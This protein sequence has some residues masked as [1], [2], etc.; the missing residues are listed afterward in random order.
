M[1]LQSEMYLPVVPLA[2]CRTWDG[3]RIREA[4]RN[5]SIVTVSRGDVRSGTIQ[6]LVSFEEKSDILIRIEKI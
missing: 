5:G 3:V 2:I 1:R 4:G 6:F